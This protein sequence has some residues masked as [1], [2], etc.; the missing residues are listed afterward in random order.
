MRGPESF[1]Y[2]RAG[3][4]RS[5][6]DCG[7]KRR[8]ALPN[9]SKR[10]A[11]WPPTA[12][13]KNQHAPR[14]RSPCVPQHAGFLADAHAATA[15]VRGRSRWDGVGGVGGA[16]ELPSRRVRCGLP[17]LI[18]LRSPRR[19]GRD[20]VGGVGPSSAIVGP[21]AVGAP[22]QGFLQKRVRALSGDWAR[23]LVA[24]RHQA[25]AFGSRGVVKM[26]ERHSK[27]WAVAQGSL[28]DS[29]QLPRRVERGVWSA[30]RGGSGD[31][32]SDAAWLVRS[33]PCEV[34][35]APPTP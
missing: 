8:R 12:R 4:S 18:P 11:V 28:L 5:S 20:L 9:S 3:H 21:G 25:A 32:T 30:R 19:V 29:P 31:R 35:V 1:W 13:P 17:A 23:S 7:S 27:K 34:R 22:A 2:A 24:N 26:R 16:G 10:L 6:A 14:G 33:S 15:S